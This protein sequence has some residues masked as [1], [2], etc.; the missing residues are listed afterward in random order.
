MKKYWLSGALLLLLLLTL[1]GCFFREPEDL[2]QSPEQSA[3]YLSLTQTIRN[4]K[5]SLAQEYGVEVEDVSVMSGDNTALIQLQDLDRDG[6]RETAVTFFRVSEAEKPLKIYFFTRTAEDTYTVS[7]MV[8][9]NGTAIYRVDYVD[10][11]GSGCK[12]VVVS[13]QMS[14]GVYLLG[15]YSLEEA[16]V[17]SLQY[18]ASAPAGSA[19]AQGLPDREALRATEWMT[20]VYDNY[21][22]YDLDQDT[23]TELAVVRVDKAGTNSA[24][25]LYGWRDGSFMVRASAPLS[26]GISS[27]EKNGVETNFLKEDG[28]VP[29]RALY[30]SSELADGHHVV[31]VVA[32]QDGNLKNLSLDETGVSREMLVERYGAFWMLARSW[33]HLNRPLRWEDEI[34]IRTWHR[35]GKRAMMY[36][37]YDIYVGD[38][39]VGES[40]SAWVLASL[41]DHKDAW[42]RYMKLTNLAGMATY[43]EL[44]ESAGMKAPFTKGSLTELSRAV[45]DWIEQHQVS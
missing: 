28:D 36:R 34:T 38:E 24:V 27:V 2:Y 4:V 30:I 17:R 44:A 19:S 35:G 45:A 41:K 40:V 13:W 39:L 22:L 12:E 5:D 42:Q 1:S 18:A 29:V 3:D 15:A 31:D 16:M 23:R 32:Y 14:T 6:E 7:A 9:G 37:D 10:L 25:D 26:M 21:A 20:T 33:F 8:E 11:N 43:T